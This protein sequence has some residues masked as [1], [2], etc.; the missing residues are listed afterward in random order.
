LFSSRGIVGASPQTSEHLCETIK[1]WFQKIIVSYIFSDKESRFETHRDF[2][3]FAISPPLSGDLEARCR[4]IGRQS[5]GTGHSG[6][7]IREV[8]AGLRNGIVHNRRER[9]ALRKAAFIN[10]FNR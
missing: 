10:H 3:L 2:A 7:Q 9:F 8:R 1:R 4:E 6:K 5:A